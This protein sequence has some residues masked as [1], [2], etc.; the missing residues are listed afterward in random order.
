[1]N[2][3]RLSLFA[4]VLCALLAASS[5][6]AQ[7]PGNPILR[8]RI[9]DATGAPVAG[10]VLEI[11]GTR[12]RATSGEDGS[13]RIEVRPGSYTLVVKR[14]GYAPEERKITVPGPE[15]EGEG[16]DLTLA[17]APVPMEPLEIAGTWSLI[18]ARGFA[19]PVA[20]LSGDRLRNGATVSLARAIEGLAGVHDLHTGEQIGKPVIRGMTGARVLVLDDGLRMEDYSWSEED[21]PSIDARLADRVEVVRGPAS[22]LFGSDA[23]GGVANAIPR[24]VFA[25]TPEQAG[26]HFGQEAYLSSNNLE[27]GGAFLAERRDTGF[28]WRVFGLGRKGDDFKTPS[29][30]LENTGFGAGNGEA[31]IG[32]RGASGSWT[33]RYAR[34]SGEFK[35]LEAGDSAAAGEGG[36]PERKAG[37]DR[38]QLSTMRHVGGIRLEARGQWQRHSLIEVA[39]E[40]DSTGAPIPGSETEQFNLLL[41]TVSLELLAHHGKGRFSGTLGFSGQLQK[42][43]TRGPIP[44]VPDADVRSSGVFAL[45]RVDLGRMSLLGGIRGD[46]REVQ[47]DSNAGL[48]LAAETRDFRELSGSLGAV[49]DL[50]NGCSLRANVGRAWRAPTL[51]ELYTNGPHLAEERYEIGRRTLAPESGIEADAG[52]RIARARVSVELNGF[53]SHIRDFIYLAPTGAFQ[54]PLRVYQ[55]EQAKARLAGG[56]ISADVKP[57]GSFTIHSR[58]DYTRGQNETLHEPLPLIPP[59]HGAVGLERGF[60]GGSLGASSA[61]LEL[62]LVAKQTRLSAFDV[63]TAGYALVNAEAGVRPNLGGRQLRIDLR[64]RNL[65]DRPYRDYLS[66]YKEFALDPGRNVTLRITRG[67]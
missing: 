46:F 67:I 45:E 14:I 35:L 2:P 47:A 63:P 30:K 6:H 37:D 29:G 12:L 17:S 9:T 23:L 44:M 25:D 34:Y 40:A 22:V 57:G 28:G 20:D 38:V 51:F 48:G 31:M 13:Y 53:Y 1:M 39:D 21:G 58:L 41:S 18:H 19:L 8:G 7:A 56:E 61:G 4:V 33:A 55:H 26:S 49:Y 27:F 66:R 59:L 24:S 62:E 3:R 54:G 16:L 65:A 43:D 32:K 15:T 42:N 5:T 11:K 64:V 60:R 52:L 50:R 10:A 36:G